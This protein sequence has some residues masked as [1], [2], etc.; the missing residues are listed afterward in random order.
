MNLVSEM[1]TIVE[2]MALCSQYRDFVLWGMEGKELQ[3][4]HI[5]SNR[6]QTHKSFSKHSISLN[7]WQFPAMAQ[8]HYVVNILCGR[9]SQTLRGPR[10]EVNNPKP[11]AMM[12]RRSRSH[13]FD[14]RSKTKCHA[15]Q[16]ENCILLSRGRRPYI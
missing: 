16:S 7:L 15:E 4:F 8:K 2:Q 6:S 13:A 1:V 3:H 14:K 12:R 10:R 5:I 11:F 9:I